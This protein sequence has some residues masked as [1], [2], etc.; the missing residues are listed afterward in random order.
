ML[1]DL[2]GV[3]GGLV[4]RPI[5]A[6]PTSVG[7]GAS[8][9]GIGADGDIEATGL[10]FHHPHPVV[11]AHGKQVIG[12]QHRSLG[13]GY[14]VAVHAVGQPGHGTLPGDDAPGFVGVR[15]ARQVRELVGEIA[16]IGRSSLGS[17][18][19]GTSGSQLASLKQA[20]RCTS[21]SQP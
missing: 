13:R 8:F 14:L 16:K 21:A 19:G 12:G 15:D 18:Q 10:Q 4:A 11:V 2:L 9:G 3:V 17:P 5:V 20:A 7:Y 1:L 6:V